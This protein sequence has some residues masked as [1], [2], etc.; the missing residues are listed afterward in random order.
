MYRWARIRKRR[1]I[2]IVA[3]VCVLLGVATLHSIASQPP[4][5]A[6]TAAT[7]VRH[8]LYSYY[9]LG[10]I[11][12]EAG[13]RWWLDR[14]DYDRKLLRR[15]IPRQ[16]ALLRTYWTRETA[17]ELSHGLWYTGGSAWCCAGAWQVRIQSEEMDG[18]TLRIHSSEWLRVR[19]MV[20]RSFRQTPK[21]PT[22][23]WAKGTWHASGQ[24]LFKRVGHR[25]LAYNL[26]WDDQFNG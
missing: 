13:G 20:A 23:R 9:N 26:S 15:L 8:A 17:N 7:L 10:T 12:G 3:L 18:G 2:G 25:W 16:E 24:V 5:P 21:G 11:P 6:K 1:V 4:I 14:N 22:V 19:Q